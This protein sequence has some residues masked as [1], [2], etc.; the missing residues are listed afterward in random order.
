VAGG[1]V[2]KSLGERLDFCV[3][4]DSS[5]FAWAGGEPRRSFVFP[6]LVALSFI[7]LGFINPA[8][9]A[10]RRSALLLAPIQDVPGP[11]GCVPA[12]QFVHAPGC[13]LQ[14]LSGHLQVREVSGFVIPSARFSSPFVF[15]CTPRLDSDS[16]SNASRR[17]YNILFY[18][19]S[20]TPDF[21]FPSFCLHPKR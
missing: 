18:P 10:A 12:E 3:A 13:D 19:L 5:G 9:D 16:A 20:L 15:T 7:F 11:R 1:G 21:Y 17:P 8:P 4:E 14:E 6:S 2:Q